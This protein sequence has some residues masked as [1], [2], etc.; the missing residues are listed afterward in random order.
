[1]LLSSQ[2]DF[3]YSFLNMQLKKQEKTVTYT[4][5]QCSLTSL[6]RHY[7]H[8]MKCKV[9]YFNIVINSLKHTMERE[10]KNINQL[11]SVFPCHS[12]FSGGF[13]YFRATVCSQFFPLRP[14]P[15]FCLHLPTI[16]VSVTSLELA[17]VRRRA[18]LECFYPPPC[19]V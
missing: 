16:T 3:S 8:Y 7:K 11:L 17:S 5:V 18:A 19:A 12:K 9:I 15:F 6:Q 4:I 13:I 1:M 14:A 2:S 10:K